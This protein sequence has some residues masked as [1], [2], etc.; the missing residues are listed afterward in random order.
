MRHNN[1]TATRAP[2]RPTEAA[3]ALCG[4]LGHQFAD[5]SLLEAAL[6]HP[7]WRNEHPEVQADNQRLEFLGDSVVGLIVARHLYEVL[8]DCREGILTV[9]MSTVV[10]ERALAAVASGIGLGEALRL[11]KGERL[12]GGRE[13]ASVLSDGLE[14][15][16][17][18]LLIDAGYDRTREI[19]L[20]LFDVPLR[21]AVEQATSGDEV[22][23]GVSNFKTAL[24]ELLQGAGLPPP[25]YAITRREG[26]PHNR[27]FTV[28]VRAEMKGETLKAEGRARSKKRAENRAAEAVYAA[29]ADHL[30]A[31]SAPAADNPQAASADPPATQPDP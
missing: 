17:G 16:F 26:A 11:G 31:A 10:N 22:H 4:R 30:T 27:R 8:P 13:L 5:V 18:A 28:E 25:S 1:G 7:S 24:Q 23:V 6:T 21:A 29:C 9:L 19:A 2:W 20:T 15:V 3:V 14:A 12:R